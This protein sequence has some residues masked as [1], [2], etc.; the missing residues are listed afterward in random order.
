VACLSFSITT[1]HHGN[2][3]LEKPLKVSWISK[4]KVFKT[5][6]NLGNYIWRQWTESHP[7]AP[8]LLFLAGI[9]MNTTQRAISVGLF[10]YLFFYECVDLIE[11][12]FRMVEKTQLMELVSI[13]LFLYTERWKWLLSHWPEGLRFV[14]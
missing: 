10:L 4:K 12:C 14:V 5:G 2:D 11:R 3:E 6:R 7:S 13:W 1:L 9:A 8:S